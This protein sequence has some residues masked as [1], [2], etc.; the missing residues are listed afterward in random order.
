MK[1]KRKYIPYPDRL[2][3]ALVELL[4]VEM[5]IELRARRA[6][7][8]AV[9]RLFTNDH[10]I[11]HALGGSDKWHNL[12]ARLRGPVVLKKNATDTT[13]VAKVRRVASAHRDFVR[14]V[15]G[16]VKRKKTPRFIWP[17]RHFRS[18]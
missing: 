4:P 3:A 12:H 13:V 17:K 6:P 8:R 7:A 5:Q 2:A 16:P 14:R 1:R 9:I 15:F 18:R 10:I 11:L